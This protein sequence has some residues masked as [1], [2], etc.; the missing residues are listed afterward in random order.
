MDFFALVVTNKQIFLLF[1]LLMAIAVT[2]TILS[3]WWI[4]IQG[5]QM[6]YLPR[7]KGGSNGV[8]SDYHTG[9]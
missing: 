9:K 5:K 6:W 4:H 2:Y 1:L 3:L 7:Y 8:N